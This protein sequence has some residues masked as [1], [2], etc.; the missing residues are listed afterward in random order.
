[1]YCDFVILGVAGASMLSISW[2]H[3]YLRN[4]GRRIS[5]NFG[6]FCAHRELAGR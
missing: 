1:L 4:L 5:E 6:V 3:L 2:F